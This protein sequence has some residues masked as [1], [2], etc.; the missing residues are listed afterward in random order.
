M[1]RC[2]KN[3]RTDTEEIKINT[4][5]AESALKEIDPTA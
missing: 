1:D 3:G 2:V 4:E 5:I